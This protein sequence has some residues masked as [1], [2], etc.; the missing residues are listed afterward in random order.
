MR[1]TL[2]VERFPITPA[3][4]ARQQVTSSSVSRRLYHSLLAQHPLSLGLSKRSINGNGL[5]Q[6]RRNSNA[7]ALEL[8]LSCI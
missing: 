1:I 2:S 5:V 4:T 8:R 3:K 7:A 6:E